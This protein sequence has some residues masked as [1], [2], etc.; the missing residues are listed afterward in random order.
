[1]KVSLTTEYLNDAQ[2]KT[3]TVIVCP[4]WFIAIIVL[5]I[6]TIIFRILA[7]KRDDRRTR[8]NSRNSTGSA[9]KFNI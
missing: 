9:D 8:A 3:A 4:L 1:M 5:I 2:I 6:A 7:K